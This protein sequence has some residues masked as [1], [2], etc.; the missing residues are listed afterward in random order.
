MSYYYTGTK[1]ALAAAGFHRGSGGYPGNCYYIH[2]AEVG[3]K[4][5]Y[6]K[7]GMVCA[8]WKGRVIPAQEAGAYTYA[9]IRVMDNGRIRWNIAAPEVLDAVLDK[10]TRECGP[11]VKK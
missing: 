5:I 7:G 4:P 9:M 6:A 3:G 10:I 1:E 8:I 2:G 11:I